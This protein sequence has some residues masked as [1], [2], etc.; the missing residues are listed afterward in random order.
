MFQHRVKLDKIHLKDNAKI[1]DNDRF[2]TVLYRI[3]RS[4]Q[5][6]TPAETFHFLS[7]CPDPVKIGLNHRIVQ[8]FKLIRCPQKTKDTDKAVQIR[9]NPFGVP[10]MTTA[11]TQSIRSNRNIHGIGRISVATIAAAESPASRGY[12]PLPLR[13]TSFNASI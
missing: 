4:H 12:F 2:Q 10:C 1:G 13:S 3:R 6:S 11:L 9:F 8:L 5:K 7:A